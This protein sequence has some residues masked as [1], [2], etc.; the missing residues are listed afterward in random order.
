MSGPNYHATKIF[1][2]NVLAII[3]KGTQILLNKAAYLQLPILEL[4]KTVI[5]EIWHGYRK[6]KYGEKA[7]LYA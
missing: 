5:Y 4:C 2:E 1:T 6:P 3:I 7:K